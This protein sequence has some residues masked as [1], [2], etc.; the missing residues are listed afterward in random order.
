MYRSLKPASLIVVLL[1][2][3][4]AMPAEAAKRKYGGTDMARQECMQRA[5]AAANA[6]PFAQMP[7]KNAM[8]V[9]AYRQCA[10]EKGIKP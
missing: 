7:E 10:R 9:D 2:T 1:V 3:A 5:Q 6:N 4:F 8:G